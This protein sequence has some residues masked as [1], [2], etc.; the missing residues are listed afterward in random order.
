V[1]QQRKS[2]RT[3]A[4]K[5]EEVGWKLSSSSLNSRDTRV[6]YDPRGDIKQWLRDE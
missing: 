6:K 1:A 4:S 5:S 3:F 2:W